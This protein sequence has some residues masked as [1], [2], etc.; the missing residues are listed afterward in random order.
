M[1]IR[2]KIIEI[3]AANSGI[4]SAINYL[5]N[6]DDLTQL[7]MNSISFIKTVVELEREFDFE[8][9]DEALDYNKYKS[10]NL[11]CDYVKKLMRTS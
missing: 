2:K 8:F 6:N 11:L 4:E 10:L 3:L 9:E 1:E 7:N 5:E